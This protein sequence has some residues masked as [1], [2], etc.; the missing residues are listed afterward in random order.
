M[1]IDKTT[2]GD[3]PFTDELE[4][5][6]TGCILQLTG[7]NEPPDRHRPGMFDD[8]CYVPR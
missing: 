4:E 8:R 2:A 5:S 3:F 6:T 7:L 1:R